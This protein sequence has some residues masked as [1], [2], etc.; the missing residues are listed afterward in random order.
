MAACCPGRNAT[1]NRRQRFTPRRLAEDESQISL[2]NRRTSTRRTPEQGLPV[3]RLAL[4]REKEIQQRQEDAA[5]NRRK[6]ERHERKERLLQEWG[7]ASLEERAHW[8]RAAT[9]R[10]TSATLARMLGRSDAQT[11]NPGAQILDEIARDRNLPPITI[12]SE[13]TLHENIANSDA[14]LDVP[15]GVPITDQPTGH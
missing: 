12:I 7:S 11:N 3:V 14:P 13:Q 9:K 15:K 1:W 4:T 10:E 6:K 5:S 2:G 8:I